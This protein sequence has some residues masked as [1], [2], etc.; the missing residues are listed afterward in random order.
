[1]FRNFDNWDVYIDNDRKILRG[2]IQFMLKDG[3][4]NANIYDA[5][6]T[7]ISNPQITDINGRTEE[8][9]FVDT[10][11]RAY[12][13][14]YVGSG[15]IANER[16]LGIDTSDQTKWAL[17]YTIESA[18]I[19][20]KEVTGLSAMGVGTMLGLRAL[21]PAQV[22]EIDGNKVVC[23]Q[24]Y[25]ECGDA[26]PVWYVW[27]GQS[28]LDDDNGSVI[29]PDS[30]LTGRWILVQP[31]EHCDS[32]HFGVFPQDSVDSTEDHSTRM[33]QLI[34]YCNTRSIRPYFN[35]SQGYPYFIYE[36]IAFQSRNPIDVSDD[37]VFIDKGT[38]NRFFGEW[39]GN[40]YFYNARTTLNAT[41][42]RHSWHFQNYTTGTFRYI[43]DSAWSPVILSNIEV[44]LEVSPASSSRLDD[45][46]LTSNEK[47][48]NSIVLENMTVHTDWFSDDYN[49]TNLSIYN[50][51]VLLDNCK[52]ANTYVLLKNKLNQA[53]YG[54]LGEQQLT[55]ATFLNNAIAENFSGTATC[56]GSAEIH[57][58]S[59][60]LTFTGPTPVFNAVD[61]WITVVPGQPFSSFSLRRGQVISDSTVSVL[62]AVRLDDVDIDAPLSVLGGV[63]DLSNCR[64][65]R[66]ISHIGNP[67]V[68]TVRNCVFNAQIQISGGAT[69]STVNAVWQD[70]VGNV[71][72]PISI[73]NTNMAFFDSAHSYTYSGNTGTFLPS[74]RVTFTHT[75]NFTNDYTTATQYDDYI[76]LTKDSTDEPPSANFRS[77]ALYEYQ[78]PGFNHGF[79]GTLSLF[80]I[81]RDV[82]PVRVDWRIVSTSSG[83]MQSLAFNLAPVSFRMLMSNAG[84]MSWH[85][86]V[87]KAIYDAQGVNTYDTHIALGLLNYATLTNVSVTGAFEAVR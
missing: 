63:L 76:M 18:S 59:A 15:T 51:N 24:G 60:T 75:L 68:E 80:R 70:N 14:K 61:S 37:T 31:T 82:F 67:V 7:P 47:I 17:Q 57:N 48:V 69:D 12:V 83:N 45:C 29:Q 11:V 41:E 78:N 34:S 22:P 19:D 28:M 74:D 6:K 56:Q 1:M 50:C 44:V 30:V 42:V 55:G 49:W 2:C 13:Y 84:G 21:D 32:R 39:N 53:D 65:N 54:D 71:E 85:C 20:E 66:A 3:S 9:V 4:T 38:S 36:N 77:D 33:T 5:D 79:S 87:Y 62:T 35:G 81:G 72:N 10:D 8:Q 40:P 64:I 46:E 43:V 27:D 25:Y 16:E 58:A 73:D 52:D 26:E 23:L 86:Y